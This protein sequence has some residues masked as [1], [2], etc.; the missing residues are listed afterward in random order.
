MSMSSFRSRLGENNNQTPKG[1]PKKKNQWYK[2][3]KPSPVRTIPLDM[4]NS[5]PRIV[6]E[7]NRGIPKGKK[8]KG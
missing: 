3:H 1:T 5:A 7:L 8:R 2:K 4:A 6:A